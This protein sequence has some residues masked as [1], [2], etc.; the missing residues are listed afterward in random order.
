LTTYCGTKN[1]RNKENSLSLDNGKGGVGFSPSTPEQEL[2]QFHEDGGE[3]LATC[4]TP[5]STQGM[6]R[7]LLSCGSC[8]AAWWRILMSMLGRGRTP[9]PAARSHCNVDGDGAQVADA[10]TSTEGLGER[11]AWCSNPLRDVH[12]GKPERKRED[13]SWG[14]LLKMESL[15]IGCPACSNYGR[16]RMICPATSLS[17]V[18][19]CS[20][21]SAG[22]VFGEGAR[23][24][25]HLHTWAWP[26]QQGKAS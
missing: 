15:L 24:H 6:T 23:D 22:G 19:P 17:H 16:L 4:S 25:S 5:E 12:P 26:D 1:E 21:S 9:A 18:R 8:T 11:P 13:I 14:F 2:P 20:I 3:L 7:A 10:R